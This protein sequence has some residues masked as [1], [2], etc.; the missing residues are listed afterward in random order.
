MYESAIREEEKVAETEAS[1][2]REREGE[3]AVVARCD[4]TNEI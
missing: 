4:Q 3:A 1:P 2:E